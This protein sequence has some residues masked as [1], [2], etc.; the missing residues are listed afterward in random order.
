MYSFT[1]KKI[2]N[3]NTHSN[4]HSQHKNKFQYTQAHIYTLSHTN[5][6]TDTHTLKH[7]HSRTHTP[8]VPRTNFLSVSNQTF[9]KFTKKENIINFLYRKYIIR[10]FHFLSTY[11]FKMKVKKKLWFLQCNISWEYSSLLKNVKKR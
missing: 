8:T 9:L 10:E 5:K 7:T 1:D 2:I 6:N 4:T 3:I 11:I